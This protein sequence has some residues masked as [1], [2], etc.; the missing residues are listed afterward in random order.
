MPRASV[1][2]ADLLHVCRA[3]HGVRGDGLSAR[4]EEQ[5]EAR[6]VAESGDDAAVDGRDAARVHS[7]QGIGLGSDAAPDLVGNHV[8]DGAP[9]DTLNKPP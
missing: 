4:C 7:D 5:T 8:R 6:Q 2:I 1:T 3:D 9:C